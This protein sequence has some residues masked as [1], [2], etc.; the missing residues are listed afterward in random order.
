MRAYGTPKRK[1]A[2]ITSSPLFASVAESTVIFGPMRQVGCA[3]AC[4]G[5][6][7]SSSARARPRNGPPEPVS[8]RVST[9][10][11]SRP[12]R[13]WKSAE[14][15]LSTGRIRPR[16]RSRAASASSPAAT[17][18]SLFASAR[19]TPRS[20]AQSVAWTPAK[21]T[22]ELRTTSGC[23]RSRSAVR[24]PPTSFSGTST[25]SSGVEPEAA[26]HSSSSGCAST[27]SIAWRPINPVAPSS[28]TRF[29]VSVYERVEEVL[30][31]LI[32]RHPLAA[33]GCAGFFDQLL[34]LGA[35]R[36]GRMV[37]LDIA[38]GG[39]REDAVVQRKRALDGQLLVRGRAEA[40]AEEEQ[41]IRLDEHHGR[42][43]AV[44]PADVLDGHADAAEV[45]VDPFGEDDVGQGDLDDPRRRQ[46]LTD[47][48][49]HVRLVG[50]VD[51]GQLV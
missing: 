12:S 34:L 38:L 48:V 8:T 5:V 13:H 4:S 51:G 50:P 42:V 35:R 26:A 22:T 14:C 30:R 28:A 24:S 45:E 20:S 23:A 3:S 41:R 39:I 37:A 36:H 6:T 19:S 18:L 40:V 1:C 11:A 2:S 7:S 27:I 17:R 44:V 43:V 21:P 25:S 49:G 16:P 29:M 10:S 47:G 32:A 31:V 9:C 33:R 46:F 15:S